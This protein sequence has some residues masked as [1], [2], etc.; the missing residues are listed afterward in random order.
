MHSNDAR[1]I[2]ASLVIGKYGGHTSALPS[3][4][5]VDGEVIKINHHDVEPSD[6]EPYTIIDDDFDFKYAPST[7]NVDE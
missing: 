6:F 4:P 1:K 5:G 3:F 2:A 7:I